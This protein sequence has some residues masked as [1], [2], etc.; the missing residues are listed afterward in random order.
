MAVNFENEHFVRTLALYFL[1]RWP[2]SNEAYTKSKA[3]RIAWRF[4]AQIDFQMAWLNPMCNPRLFS[5]FL[6]FIFSSLFLFAPLRLLLIL[7]ALC[8]TSSEF[9]FSILFSF[10][11]S[12]FVRSSLWCSSHVEYYKRVA[13]WMKYGTKFHL[14]QTNEIPQNLITLSISIQNKYFLSIQLLVHCWQCSSRM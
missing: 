8:F 9:F 12:S 2:I 13:N 14:N 6:W 7:F 3:E 1:H 5:H 4:N 10:F 11:S